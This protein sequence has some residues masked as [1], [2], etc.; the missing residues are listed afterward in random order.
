MLVSVVLS[1]NEKKCLKTFI[2]YASATLVLLKASCKGRFKK[3]K[4]RQSIRVSLTI[5]LS[6]TWYQAGLL[7]AVFLTF[8]MDNHLPG[9]LLHINSKMV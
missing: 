1:R 5:D 7:P 8:D 3:V 9:V 6:K 4:K 2:P